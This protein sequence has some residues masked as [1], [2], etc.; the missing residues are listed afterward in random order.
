M[1]LFPKILTHIYRIYVLV[2][3]LTEVD[4]GRHNNYFG[5]PFH[6]YYWG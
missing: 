5:V 2:H 4:A 3:V 1:C 6:F